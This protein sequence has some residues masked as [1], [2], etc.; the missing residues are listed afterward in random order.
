MST[1]KQTRTQRAQHELAQ[2]QIAH[3]DA[4]IKTERTLRQ[5]IESAGFGLVGIGYYRKAVIRDGKTFFAGTA[6]E[7]SMWADRQGI[8]P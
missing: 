1:P 2:A 3:L 4:K 6:W 7:C 5:R 8:A